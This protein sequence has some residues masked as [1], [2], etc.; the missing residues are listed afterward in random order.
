MEICY[1]NEYGTVCDD[2]WDIIDAGVVCRQLNFSFDNSIPLRRSYFAPGSNSSL[3]NI[4]LDNLVCNGSESSLLDCHHNVVGEHN[5]NH[6]EDSGVRCQGLHYSLSEII[7]G[8]YYSES[9]ESKQKKL[10]FSAQPR[11]YFSQA[12]GT[13]FAPLSHDV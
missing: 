11:M 4:F 8:L 13:T 7:M 12:V 9:Q 6:T 5:C 3:S 2:N 1:N 10:F